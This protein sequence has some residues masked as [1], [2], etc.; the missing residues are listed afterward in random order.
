MGLSNMGP[1]HGSFSLVFESRSG[2]SRSSS[3]LSH[4]LKRPQPLPAHLQA[5]FLFSEKASSDFF[6]SEKEPASQATSHIRAEKNQHQDMSSPSLAASSVLR[7]CFLVG[8]HHKHREHFPTPAPQPWPSVLPAT[9]AKFHQFHRCAETTWSSREARRN[10]A[11]TGSPTPPR[12]Q[13][14]MARPS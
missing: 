11:A 9:E 5:F 8:L 1:C 13:T 3:S 2:R 14:R 4:L 6:F 7:C 12:N 10:V